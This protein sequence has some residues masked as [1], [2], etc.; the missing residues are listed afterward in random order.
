LWC[1]TTDVKM[2]WEECVPLG[3]PLEQSTETVAE[4]KTFTT[5]EDESIII[6]RDP[7]NLPLTKFRLSNGPPCTNTAAD[8]YL[9]YGEL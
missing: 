9:S 7:T 1:Y 8:H 2:R 4:D 3:A 5:Y 6:S